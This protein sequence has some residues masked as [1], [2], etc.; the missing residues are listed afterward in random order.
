MKEQSVGQLFLATC[1]RKLD[2]W[3]ERI[4]HCVN[5]LED[6]QIWFRPHESMN[7]IAN[8]LL[9]LCGN[10]T[11]WI[12]TGIPALEDN[13]NRP[14]EFAARDTTP[15]TEL[16]SQL[17]I[18]IENVKTLLLDLS[19]EQLTESRRIQGF[20]ETVL[21][22]IFDSLSHLNGHTQE[23]VYITRLQLGDKYKF[24]WVPQSKEQG[25]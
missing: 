8:I 15:G 1:C 20:E 3:F 16:L 25:G 22:A 17:R 14:Q 2:D 19:D 24:A 18:V 21:S 10:L 7:S 9:H 11:Q 6:T 13:R 12:L 5:Q 4:S 23:I